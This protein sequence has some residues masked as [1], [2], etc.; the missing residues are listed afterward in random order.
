MYHADDNAPSKIGHRV[1]S[2]IASD[3]NLSSELTSFIA[4]LIV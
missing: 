2:I 4:I 3:T 1:K